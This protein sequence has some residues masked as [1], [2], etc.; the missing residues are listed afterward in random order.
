MRSPFPISRLRCRWWARKV[1]GTAV[2]KREGGGSWLSWDPEDNGWVGGFMSERLDPG[3]TIVVP[4]KIEKT[5]WL[6]E[7]KD[8]TQILY[9]IAVTAGVLIVAF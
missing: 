8:L 5:A 3:D 6:R 9:Q 2:S 7:V 4:E 1:D